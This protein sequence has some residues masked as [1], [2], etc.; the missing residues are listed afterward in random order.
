MN[1]PC[2]SGIPLSHWTTTPHPP[3]S[4]LTGRLSW[5]VSLLLTLSYCQSVTNTL[6]YCIIL[7]L[8]H[9]H[10]IQS[11]CH[12]ILCHSYTIIL[13]TLSHYHTHAVTITL[14]LSTSCCHTDILSHKCRY[15]VQCL[16]FE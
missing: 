4:L 14:S 8:S 2:D 13:P 10:S 16:S 1:I 3:G 6:S 5:Y 15:S 7:S 9:C 11:D 12:T